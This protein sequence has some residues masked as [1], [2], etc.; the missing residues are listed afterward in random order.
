M[1]HFLLR[2]LE[3]KISVPTSAVLSSEFT[4]KA[5]SYIKSINGAAEGLVRT[6]NIVI[7]Y[8]TIFELFELNVYFTVLN[9]LTKYELVF[10]TTTICIN[11]F[12]F[13]AL[14]LT[15]LSIPQS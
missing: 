14:H 5:K 3:D 8:H 4:A 13:I 11:S 7:I 6:F 15:F 1:I 10:K 12:V 2:I 9:V